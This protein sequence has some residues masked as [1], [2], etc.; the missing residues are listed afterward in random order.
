MADTGT[1]TGRDA[2]NI[3]SSRCLRMRFSASSCRHCTDIC[4]HGAATL[5]NG[6]SLDSEQCRGCLL[7]TAVC[8]TGALEQK[9][10]FSLCLTQLSR[11]PEPVLG[12]TRTREH[13][14]AALACLGGLSEEHLLTLS[15]S[16]SGELTLNLSLC[17]ECANKDMLPFL[18]KR[19]DALSK[20]GLS[21]GGC[22]IVPAESV[23]DL[24]YR[25]ESLDRRSFFKSFRKS[26]FMSA[27]AIVSSTSEQTAK[28]TPYGEKRLP[29]RRELLNRIRKDLSPE[30]APCAL[31]HFDSQADFNDN[32]TACQAC[33]SICPTG[34]L[35]TEPIDA[36]PIFDRLLCTGCGLCAEFCL[37]GALRI[38]AIDTTLL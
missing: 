11:V 23:A 4:P 29:A 35:Q 16:L 26:L 36:S 5:D 34:A 28:Q 33:V 31:V 12:C 24:R 9:T 38:S 25:D 10:D 1:A 19:L 21:D 27:A 22:H 37:D 30:V 20:A 7:C 3:D 15:H 17:E 2:L 8:P 14:N 6:L 32:C 18:R 13:S